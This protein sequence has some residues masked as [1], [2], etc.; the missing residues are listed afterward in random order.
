M[1]SGV[2]V[3]PVLKELEEFLCP[4]LLEQT[5][6]RTLDCFHFSARNLGDSPIAIH[7]TS[8]DLL[9]LKIASDIGVDKDLRELSGCDNEFWDK[10]NSVVSVTAEF[11]RWLLSRTELA[12]ELSKVLVSPDHQ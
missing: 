5:H 3:L 7:E 2:L 9:E 1:S 10:V 6:Q 11:R 12:I 8:G 4:S